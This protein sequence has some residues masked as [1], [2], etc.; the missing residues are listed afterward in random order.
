MLAV[1]IDIQHSYC[2][3]VFLIIQFK[4]CLYIFCTTLKGFILNNCFS[5]KKNIAIKGRQLFL[6]YKKEIFFP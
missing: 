4:L 5:L 1:S 6:I 3:I 2:D